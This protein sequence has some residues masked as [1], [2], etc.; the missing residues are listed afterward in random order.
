MG[1][2]SC[3]TPIQQL[4][5]NPSHEGGPSMWDSSS[6]ERLL[7]SCC[8]GVVNLTFSSTHWVSPSREGVL[9]TCCVDVV[10]LIFSKIINATC[11]KNRMSL[12]NDA[13]C[14]N[15]QLFSTKIGYSYFVGKKKKKNFFYNV[16]KHRFN[17]KRTL[18]IN[19]K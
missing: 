18:W 11:L 8:I 12:Y 5:N 17:F 6:C 14:L 16:I 1:F 10:N 19:K 4:Y 7:Y 15:I 2:D 3:T 13:T 9:C